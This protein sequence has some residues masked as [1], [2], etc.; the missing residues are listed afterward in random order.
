MSCLLILTLLCVMGA[1][2]VVANINDNNLY[3]NE[4]KNK[5][6]TDKSVNIYEEIL[7]IIDKNDLYHNKFREYNTF[8]NKYITPSQSKYTISQPIPIQNYKS[9]NK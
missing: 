4:T 7:K 1:I 3:E 6:Y 9:H 5:L 8:Y 2:V